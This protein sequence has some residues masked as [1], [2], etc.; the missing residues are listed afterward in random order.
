MSRGVGRAHAGK[1]FRVDG[2]TE[3]YRM[4]TEQ[5]PAA[6]REVVASTIREGAEIIEREARQRAPR[7]M[8]GPRRK[9]KGGSVKHRL[10]DTIGTNIRADGLMAAVGT[11]DPRGRWLEVGS[12]VRRV[13]KGPVLGDRPAQPWLYPSYKRGARHVRKEM[14]GWVA[15][16]ERKLRFKTKRWKP[17]A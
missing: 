9:W 4:L 5:L 11:S 1:G 10:R 7:S 14:R 13:R 17:K 3:A 15:D 12:K 8:G 6:F 16:A 2:L